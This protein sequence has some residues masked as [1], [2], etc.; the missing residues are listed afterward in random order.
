MIWSLNIQD[1][2]QDGRRMLKFGIYIGKTIIKIRF[3]TH[4]FRCFIWNKTIHIKWYLNI[5]S[6][7]YSRMADKMAAKTAKMHVDTYCTLYILCIQMFPNLKNVI[8]MIAWEYL[9]NQI[10]SQILTSFFQTKGIAIIYYLERFTYVSWRF[11]TWKASAW[12]VQ[13]KFSIAII[14]VP[15]YTYT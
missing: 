15:A 13:P 10:V 14:Q 2:R 6:I 11:M 5:F 4:V 12:F 9:C 7:L 1:G 3:I 8:L